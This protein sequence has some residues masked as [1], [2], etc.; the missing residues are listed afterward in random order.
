[1]MH[2][3]S[4]ILTFLAFV[5][6]T[7]GDTMDQEEVDLDVALDVDQSVITNVIKYVHR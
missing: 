7:N 2:H 4:T 5:S 3:S 1:M 6:L